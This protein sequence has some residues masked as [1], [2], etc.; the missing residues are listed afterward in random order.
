MFRRTRLFSDKERNAENLSTHFNRQRTYTSKDVYRGS[1]VYLSIVAEGA[2]PISPEVENLQV[3]ALCTNRHL[4]LDMELG[5]RSGGKGGPDF[6]AKNV[7]YVEGVR[8]L[9]GPT[10]PR[11]SFAEGRTAWRAIN[12]LSLNYLSLV[13]KSTAHTEQ[14]AEALRSLLRLYVPDSGGATQ[15]ALVD[16]LKNI[17]SAT[18]LARSPGGGPVAFIRGIDIALTMEEASASGTGIFPLASVL[19][20]FFARYVSTNH[21]TR[22]TLHTP[23]RAKAFA[24]PARVG[25][26]PVC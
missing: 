9:A 15:K 11:A 4:P 6:T 24:W 21:F 17:G 22:L 26:I 8:V 13:E 3:R 18:S 2:L 19:E 14:G 12:H 5:S 20:Q 7:A 23:E 10:P 16:G 25:R 1:E